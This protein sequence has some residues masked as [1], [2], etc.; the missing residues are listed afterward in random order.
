MKKIR[1]LQIQVVLTVFVL[2]PCFAW[3]K[4]TVTEK[5]FHLGT[6]GLPEWAEFSGKTPHGRNLSVSFE[7]KANEKEATLFLYQDDIKQGWR[8]S[9][10]G[11]RL[12]NL[13]RF[14]P[15][16]LHSLKVPAGTLKDGQNKLAVEAPTAVDDIFV[17]G[18][19]I[20]LDPL[21]EVLSQCFLEVSAFD[22]KTSAPLP[23]RFTIT[24][25][26]DFLMPLQ[27]KSSLR[28]AVRPGVVYSMDGKCKVGVLP[29]EYLVY[30][31]RGFEYGVDTI[32]VTVG[33]GETKRVTLK[34]G[35]EVPTEGW[36]SCDPH[37]HVRTF[38]GHGD[39]TVEERIPTIAGEGIELPV[40][41]DHNHHT[42]FAPYQSSAGAQSHFTSV[43][44]NEVTTKVGHF[45]A[46]PIKNGSP[47]PSHKTENW[48]ELFQSIRATPG[49]EVILLNHPRNV[50][51]EFSPTDP[52]HFNPVTGKSRREGG[53]DIDAIEVITSAALQADL[54]GPFRDWF[55]LLN[56]GRRVTAAGSSDTHDV[57]RYLLGQGRT[58][59]RCPDKDAGKI[60][61]A[62]A[63]RSFREGRALVSMGLLTKIK[64]AE[65][66]EV[67]DL[68]TNLPAK[69]VV[70]MEVL[71]PRWTI[72]DQLTLYANG[73]PILEKNFKSAQDK[74][75][76]ANLR[77]VM[78]RPKHDLYLV[79][80]ATGPGVTKPYWEIPR[81]Y[82][83]KTNKYVPRVLGATNPVWLD[84]DGD[85]LF[86][87]P[88]GYARELVEQTNGDLEKT[89][90]SLANVDEAVAAQAAGILA[91]Q[92]FDL[93]SKEAKAKWEKASS[94]SVR[95]G[96]AS[97]VS[98]LK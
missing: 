74:I 51:S 90:A 61:V 36:V 42:D 78:D 31:T 85:G 70:E 9:L 98:T 94:E 27:V 35:K 58:Y 19:F 3:A 44:G 17:G 7:S 34:I 4:I 41:T 69:V 66:F 16:V 52:S 57:N 15:K 76:K 89:L 55:A 87:F 24:D 1:K 22:K 72:A 83:H 12:G 11:K 71:G 20:E 97:F 26:K 73:I 46:F 80:I 95:R 62:A 63:C 39:S 77:H 84:G 96:F 92:G 60:D 64:V 93:R 49:V 56:S 81:P 75:S 13:E 47:V 10:N 25:T 82:Q 8:V 5:I 68:A 40:A 2:C 33:R 29:G 21:D 48:P 91:D 79:A 28:L 30:A 88:N 67:G 14:E 43:I 38:S 37:I 53:L 65:Q 23:C 86:T 32:K 18:A 59:L 6:K 54:M 45:N 50:H